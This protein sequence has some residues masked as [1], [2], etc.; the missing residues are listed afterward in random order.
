MLRRGR[1]IVFIG[2]V[3]VGKSTVIKGLAYVL[4]AK[5]LRVRRTC[6]KAFHGPSYAIWLVTSRLLGLRS[7]WLSPWYLVF[8]SGKIRLASVLTA[9]SMYMDAL[10]S[11]PLKLLW[12]RVLKALG[13]NVL[14]EEYLHTGILDYIYTIHF[15]GGWST[16]KFKP[17][18]RIIHALLEKNAPDVIVILNACD[19]T[20]LKRWSL[21]GYGDP[22]LKYVKLQRL[23]L[24]NHV[25]NAIIINTDN[26]NIKDV[27]NMIVEKIDVNTSHKV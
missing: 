24:T 23:F 16:E 3:G 4:T 21:R 14:S 17:A 15:M 9:I 13:V 25:N 18:L 8:R 12:I 20:L 19:N 27:V 1:L 5:G 11:I 6:I 22:Q 26:L 2:P 7:S 10:L